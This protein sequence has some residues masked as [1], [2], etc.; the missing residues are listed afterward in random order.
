M[1][2]KTADRLLRRWAPRNC[3]SSKRLPRVTLL[4]KTTLREVRQHDEANF[5]ELAKNLLDGFRR[6]IQQI[7]SSLRSSQ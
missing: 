1:R 4:W 5:F 2:F 7:A 3:R 6:N